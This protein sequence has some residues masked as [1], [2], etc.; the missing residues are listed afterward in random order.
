MSDVVNVEWRKVGQCTTY[1]VSNTR[2]VRNIIRGANLKPSTYTNG[3]LFVCLY[4]NKVRKQRMIHELVA[5]AF[6]PNPQNKPCIDHI[7]KNRQNN[8]VSNLRYATHSENN[9]NACKRS[10]TSSRFK[11]VCLRSKRNTWRAYI[12]INRKMRELGEFRNEK[13]AARAYNTAAIIYFGQYASLNEI[14]DDE[15]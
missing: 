2:Q 8:N 1:Q 13:E 11:G 7:D 12:N 4:N 10:N 15:D 6:L 5:Q 3:Y 9:M 14:S